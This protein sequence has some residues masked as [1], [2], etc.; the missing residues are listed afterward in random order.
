MNRIHGP[1]ARRGGPLAGLSRPH[2]S[3]EAS[4]RTR[5][6]DQAATAPP[7]GSPR[8]SQQPRAWRPLARSHDYHAPGGAR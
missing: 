2:A 8:A 3:P 6:A 7:D 1:L 4:A 5:P